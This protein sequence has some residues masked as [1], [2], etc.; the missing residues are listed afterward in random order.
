MEEKVQMWGRRIRAF[1]KLKGFTQ[2]ELAKR[3]HVSVTIVG[4]IERGNKVP[5]PQMM[6]DI[7]SILHIDLEELK[8]EEGVF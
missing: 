7:A 1:R 3:L 2:E 4:A 8:G 6:E 5:S